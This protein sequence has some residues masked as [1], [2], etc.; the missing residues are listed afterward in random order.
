MSIFDSYNV[1][2][3]GPHFVEVSLA[4]LTLATLFTILR[5]A[6]RFTQRNMT[7]GWDDGCVILA[8]DVKLSITVLEDTEPT[9]I[10]YKFL[11]MFTKLSFLILYLRIFPSRRMQLFTKG[12]IAVVVL[13]SIS[14]GIATVI[15]CVPIA[16]AWNKN[17]KGGCVNNTI[18]WYTHA[19]IN[20]F[21]DLIIYIMPIPQVLRLQL[22]FAQKA[23][24]VLIFTTG[25]FVL[26]TSI[27]RM[28]ALG[29]SSKASDPTWG[30]MTA[31]LW[32]EVEA[33][34][35]VI[36][37]CLPSLRAPIVAVYRHLFS[38][39]RS[40]SKNSHVMK[41]IGSQRVTPMPSRLDQWD[42]AKTKPRPVVREEE[43]QSVES[44][45][46]IVKTTDITVDWESI[47]S[48]GLDPEFYGRADFMV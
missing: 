34:T 32:T 7:I 17:I 12:L 36:V 39:P 48:M 20:T 24:L 22:P 23:G 11:I 46:E 44:Q 43:V 16:K 30:S 42:Y 13:W 10:V 38:V 4:M 27:M 41:T 15:Q 25:A 18:F 21:T 35:G 1:P 37:A 31:L 3:A 19:A 6:G 45:K 9:S 33:N 40:Q 14:Y 5:I 28:I 26:F 29:A 47:R 8:L 2:N